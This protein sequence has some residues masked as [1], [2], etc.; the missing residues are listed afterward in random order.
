MKHSDVLKRISVILLSL[1]LIAFMCFFIYIYHNESISVYR[2]EPIFG[3]DV[4]SDMSMELVNDNNAPAGVR[5]IYQGY[6]PSDLSQ[7][8]YLFFN[9][10]H[11]SIEVYL[12]NELVYSLIG[13][14]DNHIAKNVSSNWCILHMGKDHAEKEVTVV[15]TP[16]FEAAIGKTP[17]FLL[18][19]P[20]AITVDTIVSEMPLLILSALCILL[21][22]FV[23]SV[24]LYFRLI[25]K[26]DNSGT[27]YLGLFSIAIGLWK[28]TDLRCI[29][30][31]M[32]E[33]ALSLGY[34][35]VGSLFLTGLCL[36]SYLS[37]LFLKG[38]NQLQ[39]VFSCMAS[40]ICL[41]VLIMQLFGIAEIRQN[42]IYSHILLIVAIL[43]APLTMIINRI[44]YKSWELKKTW[45]LLILLVL[46]I[47]V[48]LIFYY[49][50]S[51]NGLLSFS[52]MGLIIY[53]LIVFLMNVQ[54]STRKAY[55]DGGTGLVNRARWIE[56]MN[57]DISPSKPVAI[58]MIDLNG[59]KQVNDTLGHKFGDQII[60]QLS[61]I[62]RKTLPLTSVICRWGGDEFTVL[63]NNINRAQ[64]DLQ[65]HRILAESEKYNA[66]HPE[67]PLHFAIG[68]ALSS[69]H[70]DASRLELFHLADEEM[71]RNKKTWYSQQ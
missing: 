69:E 36:I 7:E 4:Y 55:T 39:H 41:T 19:S 13:A 61:D 59:L 52:I 12:E 70:P 6:L 17:E 48:D 37:T 64:L 26:T 63:L 22:I 65:I 44:I 8:D 43:S 49:L 47:V 31:L 60:C 53:T 10:S 56:L 54:D 42:L 34:I 28:L 62:L 46:G 67:L 23:V 38:R 30:L 40:L 57:K 35:S 21:G 27:I 1:V 24:F 11:H 32:P 9:I 14:A 45:K 29:S 58:L 51:K 66:E 71:Y 3:Y 16:L 20:Y 68:D 5:K 33:R 2:A 50:N 15:L 25:L 18:G